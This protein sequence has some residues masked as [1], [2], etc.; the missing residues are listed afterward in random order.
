M[1]SQF[2]EILLLLLTTVAKPFKSKLFLLV[3]TPEK[4][5]HPT[6]LDHANLLKL[7]IGEVPILET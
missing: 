7:S 4:S 1:F 3:L 5:I 6:L 2:K